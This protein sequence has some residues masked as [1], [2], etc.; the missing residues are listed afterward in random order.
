MGV[1]DYEPLHSHAACLPAACLPYIALL[2]ASGKADMA[3]A[4]GIALAM[5]M[6]QTHPLT[7]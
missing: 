1:I 5:A 7:S 4:M 3:I 2:Q 6:S